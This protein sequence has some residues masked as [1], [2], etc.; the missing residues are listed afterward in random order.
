MKHPVLRPACAAFALSFVTLAASA[1][2]GSAYCTLM[3]DRYAQGTG[4]PHVGWSADLR[5]EYVRQKRL[6][7]GTHDIDADEV[8]DEEAVERETENLNLLA[9][10]GYGFDEHW[11]VVLRVPVVRRD[12]KHDLLDEETGQPSTPESWTFTRLGDMQLLGRYQTPLADAATSL[13]VFGGPEAAHGLD[14]RQQRRRRAR[15]A[16]CSRAPAPPISSAASPGATCS[17]RPT[18]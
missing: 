11:S 6:R 15:R 7:S 1:S 4:E 2:C 5:L 17:A 12:H 16:R 3:T 9:S 13:A 10:V 14:P 18:P 8:T